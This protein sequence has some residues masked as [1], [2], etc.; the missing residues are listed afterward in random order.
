MRIR[1][2]VIAY[3]SIFSQCLSRMSNLSLSLSSLY[4][5]KGLVAHAA[6]VFVAS[7]VFRLLFVHDLFAV[8]GDVRPLPTIGS[9][10][11]IPMKFPRWLYRALLVMIGILPILRNNILACFFFF[12]PSLLAFESSINGIESLYFPLRFLIFLQRFMVD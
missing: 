6:R 11:C 8:M 4:R 9:R 1:F 5:Q 3:T 12:F 2:L 7:L 10:G